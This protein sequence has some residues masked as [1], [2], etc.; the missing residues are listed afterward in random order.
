MEASS[1]RLNVP[2]SLTCCILL[3]GECLYLFSPSVQEA[4]L[5]MA[6]QVPDL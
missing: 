2:R 5:M 4:S 3:G 6:E 1:L